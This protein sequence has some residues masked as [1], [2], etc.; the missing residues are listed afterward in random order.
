MAVTSKTIKKFQATQPKPKPPKNYAPPLKLPKAVEN[1]QQL[2][3]EIMTAWKVAL[4]MLAVKLGV[5]MKSMLADALTQ[6]VNDPPPE[7][8]SVMTLL[9][10][11]ERVRLPV[12]VAPELFRKVCELAEE[13]NVFHTAIL[14]AAIEH[15]I[16]KYDLKI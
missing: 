8:F 1:E 13:R 11:I 5:T 2:S 7:I 6:I 9:P 4:K 3:V 15:L 10:P 12:Y 16:K 14:Q